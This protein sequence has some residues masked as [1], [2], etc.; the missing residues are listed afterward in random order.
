M[1]RITVTTSDE[2]KNVGYLTKGGFGEVYKAT[3]INR[4]R[5]VVSERVHNSNDK[6][7]DI[8]KEMKQGFIVIITIT[9]KWK[10]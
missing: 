2:F 9:L 10:Q 8:L 4:D 3:W 6:I 7:A 1:Q 5:E